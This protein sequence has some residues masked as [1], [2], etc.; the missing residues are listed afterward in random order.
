[1]IVL[2]VSVLGFMSLPADCASQDQAAA[3]RIR[4]GMV[5]LDTS[6]AIAFTKI[7]NATDA[8]NDVAGCRVVAAYPPGS[9]DIQSS[10]VRVPG[11]TAE[12]RELGVEIVDSLDEL[13]A[14]VDAV[15]LET[16]D[17]RPHLQQ[18]RPLLRAGKPV[19]ID[20]PLAGSLADAVAIYAEAR[21][22][23]VP[24]FS[25]SSLR[26]GEDT[27]AARRGALGEVTQCETHSPASHE[28]THSDLYWYGIHG[29]E[30]LFTVM[31]TGC[32]HV[33][34]SRE[35][36]K[37]KVVG[38]WE[39][40]RIGIFRESK[41]YGGQAVGKERSGPVGSYDGYRPLVVEI[42]KFFRT[43]MP[44]VSGQETL[45]IYAFMTAAE[46]SKRLN[47]AQVA[48]ADV[49]AEARR[50]TTNRDYDLVIYGGTSAGVVAAIQARR[51]GK[52]AV[53]I[54]P[55]EHLGGL[56]T[57]G[58]G[59]TD[60]G[61]K[62]VIGGIAREFYQRLKAY[63]DQSS[64]WRYGARREEYDRYRADDDAMWTFEPR[65][66]EMVYERMLDEHGVAVVR[67]QRLDRQNGVELEGGRIVSITTQFGATYRGKIFVDATYEGD[68]MAAAGVTYTVGR[69]SNSQYGET[70]NGVQKRENIH[71]H[72]FLKPVDPYITLGD[73]SSGL[74]PGIDG[75][76]P[77][78]EGQGDDRV[79]AYCFRM[80]MSNVADNQVPFPKPDGYDEL[81]YELLLRNFEAG[82]LRLPLKLDL[83]PNGKTDTNNNCAVST[84]NLGMNYDYPDASYARRA[85]I[86]A[87]HENYQ[88]GLM[89]TLSNHERIPGE[90]RQKMAVWGLA[91]DEF[92]D[93]G[94]W[95][96]QMYIREARRMVSDYVMTEHDCRSTRA[97]NGSIGMGSYNMDSHNVQRY[98]TPQGH[99][100]NEGD[101]QVSPGGAYRISY[102]A[103]VPAQGEAA[104]LLVPV[105]LSSSHIAYGSIR[106][107][108]VFM[109]LGQSVASA[110][111]QAIDRTTSVQDVDYARLRARLAAD[112]QVLE[113]DGPRPAS[114]ASLDPR[115]LPGLVLDDEVLDKS[116]NWLS[117][118]S[119]GGFVGRKYWHDNNESQGQKSARFPFQIEQEG[120]Y[121]VRLSYTAHSNR[122]TNVLVTIRHAS[123]E[124]SRKVNQRERPPILNA[125]VSLGVFS[126]A[127]DQPYEIVI[128]NTGADGHVIADAVQLLKQ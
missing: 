123:G 26:Y 96:H 81:R 69:E 55:G 75:D 51:M 90:V 73:P 59:W 125:F 27:L 110:A 78:E 101:V 36:G 19:F 61:N 53:I 39:N 29:V 35:D 7:L 18:L 118:T 20:K 93:N 49:L 103:V 97:V 106:M 99:V 92:V 14:K 8:L 44:P 46:K 108:P 38:Q 76:P 37:L 12:I 68:L 62:A 109:V 31:G 113:H 66:A 48:I 34:W 57:G 64:V 119:V 89:W 111:V 77:A 23:G 80:C 25:S 120:K 95:P 102:R 85:E 24:I 56:T 63:Y 84:D 11:Y 32:T 94:N 87:E 122:A 116:G 43:K 6:H 126:F 54:E 100:Q 9:P 67:Y 82:D 79:Q 42:V 127:A 22:A 47:G 115:Q 15:L 128:S 98:V 74:L 117:S 114:V 4:V 1:M 40:G 41:G 112:G 10:V 21:H 58:L 60:S 5:G 105:C 121:E 28:P 83:M 30:S 71:K 3:P 16:N 33:R 107:E 70:L 13:I 124:A 104:N 86:L 2:F 65:I 50:L 52:T 88:K 17:G 72:R 91:A 45:E